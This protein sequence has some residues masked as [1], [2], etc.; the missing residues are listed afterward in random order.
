MVLWLL[1]PTVAGAQSALL[2]EPQLP[3]TTEAGLQLGTLAGVDLWRDP[4]GITRSSG[5]LSQLEL[6]TGL[7]YGIQNTVFSAD[8][9][10]Q[11]GLW[12]SQQAYDGHAGQ[13]ALRSTSGLGGVAAFTGSLSQGWWAGS[14]GVQV[15]VPWLEADAGLHIRNAQDTSPVGLSSNVFVGDMATETLFLGVAGRAVVLPSDQVSSFIDVTGLWSLGLGARTALSGI[16][17]VQHTWGES[18]NL[19]TGILPSNAQFLQTSLQLR[20]WVSPVVALHTEVTG[21]TV[22]GSVDWS[23]FNAMTGLQIRGRVRQVGASGVNAGWVRLT[24]D[25]PDAVTVEVSGT[26]TNWEPRSMMHDGAVWYCDVE[27]TPG[28]HEYIY[29]VDK[30]QVVPPESPYSVSD[31]YGGQNGVLTVGVSSL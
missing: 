22:F 25:D 5:G 6:T 15:S 1:L 12:T 8:Q 4:A 14:T 10:T 28:N 3:S 31:G 21:E 26:F 17:G 9:F 13:L 18:E 20:H 30:E 24:Y 7:E 27:L 2:L 29:L 11:L 19:E 16:F 23:R